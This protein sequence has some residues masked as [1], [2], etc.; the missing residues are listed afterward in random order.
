LD[1]ILDSKRSRNDKSGLGYNKEEKYSEDST[2]KKNE[3]SHSFS[4]G[5]NKVRS[6]VAT[7]IKETFKRIE[8]RRY[9]EAIS[10]PQRKFKR[11]TPKQR[12]EFFFHGNYFS[13][14]EYGHKALDH[15][16][17]ERKDVGRFHNIL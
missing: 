14:N 8:K 2:S 11:E 17:Y 13:C 7:Q 9:Q 1:E 6:H 12:Y 4:K 3:V 5:G 15:I 16:N 10:T